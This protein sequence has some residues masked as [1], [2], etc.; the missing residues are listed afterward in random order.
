MRRIIAHAIATVLLFCAATAGAQTLDTRFA[1]SQRAD[2][3]GDPITYADTGEIHL[4]GAAVKMFRW[5]SAVFRSTHGYD[6]NIDD[7]DG[8]QAEVRGDGSAASWR[9]ALK[10]GGAARLKRGY[11]FERGLNCTIRLERDGNTVH[12]KPTC[13]ALCGSRINFSDIVID[14]DSGTCRYDHQ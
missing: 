2:D 12:V 3:G 7:D 10:D 9:V 11:N 6:C 5:E 14:L 13:P 8:L 1:C 4:D